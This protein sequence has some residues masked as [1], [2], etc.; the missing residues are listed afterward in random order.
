[1]M[2]AD[3]EVKALIDGDIWL[4]GLAASVRG[5]RLRTRAA[6]VRSTSWLPATFRTPHGASLEA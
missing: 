2:N 3:A 6:I 5:G 1:M 4:V